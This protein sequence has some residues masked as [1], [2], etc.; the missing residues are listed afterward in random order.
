[1]DIQFSLHGSPLLYS[2]AEALIQ[3]STRIKKPLKIDIT[4]YVNVDELNSSKLFDLAVKTKNQ[5]LASL[6]F[7]ISVSKD[8]TTT[9]QENKN[10]VVNI[11]S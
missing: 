8:K 10:T 4:D 2:E 1:M 11:L 3:T 6:A 7:K 9:K 5:E